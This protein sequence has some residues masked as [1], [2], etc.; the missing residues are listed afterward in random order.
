MDITPP[1]YIL[2]GGSRVLR[3]DS[4]QLSQYLGGNVY[5]ASLLSLTVYEQKRII[6]RL[7]C[8]FEVGS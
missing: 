5:N 6:E 2:I 4:S 1:E 8:K 3:M 7:D